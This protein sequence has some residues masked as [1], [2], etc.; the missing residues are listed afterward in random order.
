MLA[1]TLTCS[2][3]STRYVPP[4][5]SG[6]SNRHI[7]PTFAHKSATLK[8][9]SLDAVRVWVTLPLPRGGISF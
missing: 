8:P 1:N 2:N 4:P 6:Q 7:Y 5:R 9:L 3:D